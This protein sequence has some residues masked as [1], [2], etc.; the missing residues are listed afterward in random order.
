[1]K[2]FKFEDYINGN[3]PEPERRALEQRLAADPALRA[4]LEEEEELLVRL[5]RQMLRRQVEAAMKAEPPASRSRWRI[6]AALAILA[7]A[8]LAGWLLSSPGAVSPEARPAQEPPRNPEPKNQEVLPTEELPAKQELPPPIA[9]RTEPSAPEANA[10]DGLRSA[11]VTPARALGRTAVRQLQLPVG[12]SASPPLL[13][14]AADL[15]RQGRYREAQALLEQ[16]GTAGD[17]LLFLHAFCLLKQ[18]KGL[19]AARYFTRLE[20]PGTAFAEESQWG[21][22][23][24]WLLADQEAWAAEQLE[25]IAG[26]AGHPWAA[27]AAELIE[28]L[29]QQR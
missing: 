18:E 9:Q 26:Q 13:Q 11:V 29:K 27:A 23:L 16:E 17:T 4:Q 15:A 1:M 22:A 8:L 3:L 25:A 14:P 20:Q 28:Q 5:K 24:S 2:G 12:A 10:S 7:A 21:L 6:W 19:E